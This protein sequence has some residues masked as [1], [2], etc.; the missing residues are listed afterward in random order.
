MAVIWV[1]SSMS[2]DANLEWQELY[3]SIIN[4]FACFKVWI[5]IWNRF[6]CHNC[7]NFFNEKMEWICRLSM[8]VK[9]QTSNWLHYS[10]SISSVML[11]T[12][13][14]FSEPFKQRYRINIMKCVP[15]AEK[16]RKFYKLINYLLSVLDP[17][18]D[19]DSLF[20]VNATY[21]V[22]H[23]EMDETKWLWGVE[24][25]IILLNHGA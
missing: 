21:R 6:G 9:F 14:Q 4:N 2:S 22:Y 11:L 24:G 13:P 25:S 16:G 5:G 10:T 15:M 20:L 3:S 19:T 1:S 8:K 12:Y 18:I 7:T 17:L 23:I